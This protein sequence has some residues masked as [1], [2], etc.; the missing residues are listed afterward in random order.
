MRP[1]EIY[2]GYARKASRSPENSAKTGEIA[3]RIQR[4][5]KHPPRTAGEFWAEFGGA[6]CLAVLHRHP[7]MRDA[8]L[9]RDRAV[10]R[11]LQ[12][13]RP[14]NANQT[15]D[16]LSQIMNLAVARSHIDRNPGRGIPKN[17]IRAVTRFLSRDEIARLHA[18]LDR[19]TC[20]VSPVQVDIIRL[21]LLT[22]CRSG[23]ILGLRWSE[24]RENTLVL[25]DAKTGPRSVP[26]N[27]PARRILE[28]QPRSGSPFMFP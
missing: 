12:P 18:A 28:R 2:S 11:R 3:G 17:L 20:K 23:K 25:A 10:V 7:Q 27:L 26:L 9:D 16:L 15:L 6:D 1:V 24:V 19:Q 4:N 13:D 21:L 5:S 8:G 22:D 14:G